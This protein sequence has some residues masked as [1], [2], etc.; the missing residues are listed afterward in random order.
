MGEEGYIG[1]RACA[2][3]HQEEYRD[4]LSTPHATAADLL[5]ADRLDD[6][7]C[8]SCHSTGSEPHLRQVQCES[9]H[10]PGHDYWP[11]YVMRDPFLA[12]ALGMTAADDPAVCSRCHT[13]DTPSI[14]PFDFRRSLPLV[15][16]PGVG[17]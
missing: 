16:H 12:R 13:P 4:W 11:D 3:C 1:A 2:Q 17:R 5:P 14:E 7:A 10:G 6:P 15:S 8:T 9:C